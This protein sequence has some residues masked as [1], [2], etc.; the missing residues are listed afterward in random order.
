MFSKNHPIILFIDRSGFSVFQDTLPNIPRFNFT[1]DA[2]VNLD[3]VGKEK[4]VNLITTFIQINKIIPSSLG[5]ILSD[6][7]I[8]D[9]NLNPVP[10]PQTTVPSQPESKPPVSSASKA[11]EMQGNI[12]K[13]Q[14]IEIQNFLENV[15]FEEVLAKVIKINNAGRIVAVNK[16][17]VMTIVDVFANKGAIIEA[18]IPSFMYGPSINFTQGLTLNNIQAILGGS[19]V[20][21]I[22]NL[23]TDQQRV[24]TPQTIEED[25]QEK[26]KK[27]KN[28]RQY[29]LI[30]AFVILLLI[31]GVVYLNM[32]VSQAPSDK[33]INSPKVNTQ[34]SPPAGGPTKVQ[35]PIATASADIKNIKVK[36]VQGSLSSTISGSLKSQLLGIGFDN[37]TDTVVDN[38]SEKPSVLFSQNISPT[39]QNNVIIEI[40]KILP[41]ISVLEIQDS[42]STITISIGKI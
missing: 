25:K 14:K 6:T 40:K 42:N 1:P 29:I 13:E 38:I 41:D 30:G 9:K 35:T 2:V 24:N 20:L 26:E 33:K 27:P 22:G 16:D 34:T 17:L 28:M 10:A 21:R 4:F 12:D 5:V 37:I 8:Y 23:L 11:L 3:V 32:G 19:E 7:V 15:P 39:I 36:I 18:I 31:L